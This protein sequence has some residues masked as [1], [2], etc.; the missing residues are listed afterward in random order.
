MPLL[1]AVRVAK[2]AEAGYETGMNE[3]RVL[4][5]DDDDDIRGLVVEPVRCTVRSLG[6]FPKPCADS[7]MEVS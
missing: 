3:P 2:A 1:S 5:I 4:V 7:K 6:A